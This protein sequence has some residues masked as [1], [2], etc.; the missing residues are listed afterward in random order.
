MIL[1][2]IL[3]RNP[4]GRCFL[5][6]RDSATRRWEFPTCLSVFFMSGLLSRRSYMFE[7]DPKFR[8]FLYLLW[9]DEFDAATEI[10]T[11]C[12]DTWFMWLVE[13]YKTT[14]RSSHW[15]NCNCID[16]FLPPGC[17][18]WFSMLG[19]TRMLNMFTS[20]ASF[21]TRL[22]GEMSD[23]EGW[24]RRI[25][26]RLPAWLVVSNHFNDV[27]CD[28]YWSMTYGRKE[29]LDI[30]ILPGPSWICNCQWV[31]TC[32]NHQPS[33]IL[34][35]FSRWSFKCWAAADGPH[36]VVE[37]KAAN[38]EKT[39]FLGVNGSTERVLTKTPKSRGCWRKWG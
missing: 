23:W 28:W 1:T 20:A 24:V 16:V 13:F 5:L 21:Q 18:P 29:M 25:C 37:E 4:L 12:S 14:S 22:P 34:V 17:L 33:Y 19:S 35:V 38:P 2:S 15:L 8:F 32:W 3:Q 7:H 9:A 27:S 30:L 26:V 10:G 39:R 11:L 6:W 36:G 31:E